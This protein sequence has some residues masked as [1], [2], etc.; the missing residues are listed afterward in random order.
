M[1]HHEV[2]LHIHSVSTAS[3][4]LVSIYSL[5]MKTA[6]PFQPCP[7][8]KCT[9]MLH[10]FSKWGQVYAAQSRKLKDGTYPSHMEESY[11]TTDFFHSSGLAN[12]YFLRV[13]PYIAHPFM[14]WC[15][16]YVALVLCAVL[17]GGTITHPPC[18]TVKVA[19]VA[20]NSERGT[21]DSISPF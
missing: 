1:W 18:V 16:K 9:L 11:C 3:F 13:L 17:A 7:N 6:C 14:L 10:P 5:K 2:F 4:S 20:L 8:I 19:A 15:G 21:R 12:N